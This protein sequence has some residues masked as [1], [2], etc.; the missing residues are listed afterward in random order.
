MSGTAAKLQVML[1][2]VTHEVD[3][4]PGQRLIE[5]MEAAGLNPPYNCRDG[6]CGT[7]MCTLEEGEVEL[8]Q[9]QVLN[10]KDLD[11]RWI[12]ACQAVAQSPRVRVKFP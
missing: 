2:G 6:A 7:C 5:A 12:I 3:V 9:N 4:V 8:V 10:Q 1:D 11:E